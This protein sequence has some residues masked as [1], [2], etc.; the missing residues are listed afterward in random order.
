MNLELGE[1]FT[2]FFKKN[3]P[4]SFVF[5][6]VLTLLVAIS[7]I[8][9][10][11]ASFFE[12]IDAWYQGF[13]LLLEFGM[14]MVLLIVTGYTIALSPFF[15]RQ[16]DLLCKYIKNPIQVYFIVT[17][18][19]FLVSMISW[20]WIVAAA[21]LG[22]SLANRIKGVNYPFLIACTYFSNNSWVTG[23]SSSIPLLLNTKDNYLIKAGII[24]NTIST[25]QTLGSYLNI[26]VIL[27]Y[28]FLGT[29]IMLLIKPKT[30]K[31]KELKDYLTNSDNSNNQNSILQ[32]AESQKLPFKALSDKLNNSF[33][34]ILIIFFLGIVYTTR[35]FY[36]NGFDLNLNIMIFIFLMF[37][38]L[39]H[40]NSLRFSIAMRRSSSNV[41]SI[42]FQ[43]PFYAGIMGIM[44]YTGLGES[45]SQALVSVSS[46]KT[47]PFFSFLL[48][49]I[50][51]FAIPSGGGEFAVIGPSVLEA[52]K[53]IGTGLSPE[54]VLSMI[55]RASL[56][57]A[58]GETLTNL[59][60]PFYL[61][62][63]LPIMGSGTNLQARDIM[64]YL[65][66]PFVAFFIIFSILITYVPLQ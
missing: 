10:A 25:I 6:L 13:W 22:R 23:L 9:V 32:E 14:Q 62:L 11:N 15:L 5:A 12:I 39:M 36:M 3:M 52:V 19:G 17:L 65:V 48:G 24:E 43:F 34:L 55:S 26:T 1:K 45:L 63:V 64:G 37:G 59:L 53:I 20:G 47:F 4:D 50:V 28:L 51:N 7:A 27:S 49:G 58:Y 35:Y 30:S 31:G 56:S 42:L 54:E 44:I 2:H 66:I 21:A 33:L 40:K 16:I 29:L 46:L 61:L 38:L 60:Q 8:F 18:F 41:S 57:I